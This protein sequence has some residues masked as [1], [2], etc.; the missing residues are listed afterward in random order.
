VTVDPADATSADVRRALQVKFRT[1]HPDANPTDVAMSIAGEVI[2]R[3]AA[4]I[5]K[6]REALGQDA[7]MG[8][9]AP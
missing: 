5:A 8:D 7:G 4:V 1:C 3:Q 2:D 9:S 6:L